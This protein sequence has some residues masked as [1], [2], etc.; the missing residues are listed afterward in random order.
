ML[1]PFKYSNIV[2]G[3]SFCN[4]S[5]E[6]GLL[7][8]FIKASQNVLLYSHRRTG[9]SSLIKQVFKNI[10][11]QKLKI[12]TL[13]IDLYGT[14]SDKEFITRAF[15]QLNTLESNTDKL[16]GLLKDS[17]D[18]L[19][20]ELSIDPDTS[21][22]TISPSFKAADE[23]VVLNNLMDLLA[24][25]SAK[26]KIVVVFDEFQEISKYD[27]AS[28]FEKQL[29]ASI[30]QHTNISYIFSGSQQHILTSMF[31][32][33]E[34]AFYQ[35][36]ASFPLMVIETKH[37]TPWLE[38]IFKE[39]KSPISP[40]DIKQ[41]VERFGNHPMYIQLFCFFLWEELRHCSWDDKT[42]DKIE[43]MMVEQKHLEYQT[44]W[45]NL[46]INQKKTLKLV[47]RNDGH[48][49]FSAK[50][51]VSANIKTASVVTRCL[52]SLTDKEIIVKNGKYLIQDILFR[53][54]MSYFE[55]K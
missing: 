25:F 11:E 55:S 47:L 7:L 27:N 19:S 14:T 44:L 4:R 50:S 10:E 51:L 52:N 3:S 49:L 12:G 17:V 21:A 33:Q 32:S 39:G 40:A 53:K 30:Q 6:Q 45:D 31:T 48:N 34:R 5:S 38:K 28:S 13:Y 46:S 42:I 29:R 8:E 9:K 20:F 43:R 23:K 26:K 36:A 16:L 22:T 1:N 24:K 37:Y 15:Q 54:W 35:Q 41:I 18:K 2:T